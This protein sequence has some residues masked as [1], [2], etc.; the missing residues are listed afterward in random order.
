M[1]KKRILQRA[2][3][4]CEENGINDFPVNI[5]EL[6]ERQGIKVFEEYLPHNVSGFIVIQD[7]NFLGYNSNRVIV[8]NLSDSAKRRRFTIAHELAH[9]ILHRSETGSLYAHR[10]AGQNGGI[11]TEANLFASY[12]LMPTELVLKA[13]KEFEKAF[14]GGLTLEDKIIYI[15]NLFAVSESAAQVRLSQLNIS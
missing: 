10:D 3:Q 13:L 14:Y 1:E 7:K 9:Y 15:S 5:V 12:I 2:K 4:F 8:V 11:E 6:C